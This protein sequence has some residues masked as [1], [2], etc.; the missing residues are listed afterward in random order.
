MHR[1]KLL[2][3]AL[4][5]T[6]ST[7]HISAASPEST[8]TLTPSTQVAATATSSLPTPTASAT[9]PPST[10][11]APTESV[12]NEFVPTATSSFPT[13]NPCATPQLSTQAAPTES[14]IDR[15]PDCAINLGAA[16]DALAAAD[17]AASDSDVPAALDSVAVVQSEL[18]QQITACMGLPPLTAE[19]TLPGSAL[20][21][22]YPEGWLLEP[23]EDMAGVTVASS[24]AVL[25]AALSSGDM[26]AVPPG[27]YAVLFLLMPLEDV[28]G[29]DADFDE[30]AALLADVLE[31]DN[32]VRTDDSSQLTL[33]GRSA[34][35]VG[36]ADEDVFALIDLVDYGELHPPA[37]LLVMSM[38]HPSAHDVAL[39][40]SEAFVAATTVR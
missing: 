13:P 31:L 27:E 39:T 38:A 10:Q 6:V 40:L 7:A 17:A 1:K 5:L 15:T 11:L 2:L 36:F 22:H 26:F 23:A 34:Y 9:P 28:Y 33:A 12:V 18:A 8:P 20:V 35:R 32:L 37:L 30:V 19:Y 3:L 24:Q 14:A 21:L 25:D 16:L 4:A 29:P